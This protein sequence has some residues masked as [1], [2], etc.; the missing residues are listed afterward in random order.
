MKWPWMHKKFT[1]ESDMPGYGSD[2]RRERVWLVGLQADR[3][4]STKAKLQQRL[5]RKSAAGINWS[6]GAKCISAT[7]QQ[8]ET[9]NGAPEGL[10]V[11]RWMGGIICITAMH[12]RTAYTYLSVFIM[13]R[14]RMALS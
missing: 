1:P 7:W 2:S 3:E 6:T 13:R 12:L 11:L 5:A 14:S 10:M 4:E 9:R 8:S